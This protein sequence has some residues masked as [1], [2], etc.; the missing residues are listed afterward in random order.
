MTGASSRN[1]GA[2][3]ALNAICPYFT[4]FPLSFPLKVL[5]IPSAV[6]ERRIWRHASAACEP[7]LLTA[8][9]SLSPLLRLN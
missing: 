9:P 7:L 3:D 6:E 1:G 4:M 8:L 2:A 5:S